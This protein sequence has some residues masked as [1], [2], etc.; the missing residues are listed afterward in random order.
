MLSSAVD[1]FPFW[2]DLKKYRYG[3]VW[4][5][6]LLAAGSVALFTLPQAMAYAFVAGLPTQVGIFSAIFGTLF[7]SAFGYS[8][9]LITGPTTQTAILLQSGLSEIIYTYYP[10]LTVSEQGDLAVSLMLQLVLLVGIFQL[11]AG[12]MRLGRLTQFTSRSVL[13]GYGMGVAIAIFVTQLFP[14]F[15]IAPLSGNSP[16]Y[17]RAWFFFQH[18]PRTHLPTFV[19][20]V[21]CLIAF[22]LS[23]K[24]PKKI[25]MPVVIFA[26]AA[27]SIQ[28]LHLAPQSGTS[29]LHVEEG[30]IASKITLLEDLGPV[31]TD[32]PSFHIPYIELTLL[33]SLIPLAF[34]I[35]LLSVLQATVIGRSYVRSQDPPYN[36]NQEIF[37]LGVGNVL[38]ACL[39]G[40]PSG[41]NYA[42]SIL[43][44]DL[45]AQTRFAGIFSS[46]ILFIIVLFLGFFV[47]KIPLATLSALMLLT[48]YQML[49]F[50]DLAVCLR[51]TRGDA[52]ALLMTLL[53]CFFFTFDKAL[54]IGVAVSVVLYLK[55]AAVPSIIEYTF[56]NVGKLRPLDVDDARS[57]SRIAIFQAEGELFFGAADLLQTKLR[58][59]A[60][61]ESIRILILQLLNVRHLDASVC[62]ALRH[63]NKYLSKTGRKLLI[64][65]VSEEVEKILDNSGLTD[66]IGRESIFIYNEQLPGEA[67]RSAYAYAKNLLSIESFISS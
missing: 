2:Q 61:D 67:T 26:L 14:F 10:H 47:T 13:A 40:M 62:L 50:S 54:Y 1:F 58:L 42:R 5:K 41:G 65:G 48:S 6:D 51:A 30:G 55:Q 38:C 7:S 17:Q 3:S 46:L 39:G 49:N 45:G 31:Y 29:I 36:D 64:S 12:V 56:T 53:A 15:G 34:A 21:M 52:F 28:I 16:L 33:G 60:E 37:G 25:P 32:L 44:H 19:L 22:I 27:L 57:D 8:R 59:L 4:L 43:N 66:K 63:L 11:L 35:A 20:G 23:K 24:I 9:Y 18:L